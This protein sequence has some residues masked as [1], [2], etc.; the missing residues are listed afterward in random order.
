MMRRTATAI[1]VEEFISEWSGFEVKK[2][3]AATDS[4]ERRGGQERKRRIAH[5]INREFPLH[6]YLSICPGVAPT[7]PFSFWRPTRLDSTRL[8]FL[9]SSRRSP[10]FLYKT[11]IALISFNVRRRRRHSDPYALPEKKH[12]L[13]GGRGGREGERERKKVG[14]ISRHSVVRRRRRLIF[15]SNSILPEREEQIKPN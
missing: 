14:G 13:R 10:F 12:F 9:P 4:R 6:I 1:I 5:F 3:E 2:E 8:S 11:A 7:A 15:L